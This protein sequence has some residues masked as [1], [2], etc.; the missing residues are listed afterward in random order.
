MPELIDPQ[1]ISL[2]DA[3]SPDELTLL[4]RISVTAANENVAVYMVGGYVRDLLLKHPSTDFDLVVDGDAIAFAN[5][6]SRKYGG[7]V[8]MHSRFGTAQ[9]HTPAP[10]RKILDLSST[11]SETYRSSAALPDVKP[12]VFRDD[13]KR[14]DFTVN[15]LAIRLDGEHW[16]EFHDELGGLQDLQ[17]GVLRVLHPESFRDD[18]TRLFRLV[19]YEQR[20]A[21]RISPDT[22]ILLPEALQ[23]INSLSA[24]RLRHEFDLILEENS[25]VNVLSRLNELDVFQHIHPTIPWDHSIRR[26]MEQGMGRI[27]EDVEIPIPSYS[28]KVFLGWHFWLMGLSV[29]NLQAIEDRLHFQA[30]LLRSLRWAIVLYADLT[31][32]KEMQ[33]TSQVVARLDQLPVTAVYAVYLTD[34]QVESQTKLIKYLKEWRYIK[35]VTN[36]NTLKKLGLIPSP[37][38]QIILS[39]LRQAWL[40]GEVGSESEEKKLLDELI[41]N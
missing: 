29:D 41:N 13:L 3:L 28:N 22:Q 12:V 5:V 1:E 32:L 23:S 30:N 2:S 37:R 4:R 33:T 20:Y 15:T 39:R 14:R 26:R 7:K 25:A 11:R 17:K 18:P 24:E 19:R 36:G 9:W 21:F 27:S 35:P 8:T 40:D 10:G 6:L 38:F 34:T 31:A 16:G